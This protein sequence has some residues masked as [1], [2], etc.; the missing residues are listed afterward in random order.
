MGDSME[1]NF[2]L[3]FNKIINEQVTDLE[4]IFNALVFKDLFYQ[5]CYTFE[6]NSGQSILEYIIAMQK[7]IEVMRRLIE[8][9]SDDSNRT[10]NFTL[11]N[12]FKTKFSS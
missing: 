10:N 3:H 11:L 7:N 8:K 1:K 4:P 5:Y 2:N 12:D 6:Q 9:T